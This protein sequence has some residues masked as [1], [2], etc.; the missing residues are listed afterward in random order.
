MPELKEMPINSLH[1]F[2]ED[3]RIGFSDP[4]ILDRA[5]EL[6]QQNYPANL[7]I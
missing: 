4:K 3:K 1:Y 6:Q 2:Y 7:D 5:T